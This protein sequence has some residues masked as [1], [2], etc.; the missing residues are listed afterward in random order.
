MPLPFFYS[1]GIIEG[2]SLLPQ[3]TSRH[4]VQVLR[5][6]VG[7]QL[8]I[9]N[10]NGYLFLSEIL[11][12]EKN[13]V[14]IKVLQAEVQP[15]K[16]KKI[17]IAISLVKNAQRFEWFL[18]KAVEI[19]VS[20]VVPL[21]CKRTEKQH[22]RW[23]RMQGIMISAMLQS[24]QCMLPVL[25]Q[26]QSLES[27]LQKEKQGQKLIAHCLENSHRKDLKE[28]LPI[29]NATILIGPEG[30][31]TP[32]EITQAMEKNYQPITLGNTRLRTETAGMVAVSLLNN[33]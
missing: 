10:G 7:E 33:L 26:P 30:D 29:N 6:K 18:E 17:C 5:M 24:R 15:P 13:G 11:L 31:F 27:F 20:E 25:A 21:L 4:I 28:C 19:G 8:Y 23:D 22:F 32:E 12:A 1:E 3:D 9:T 14:S 2:E 16:A